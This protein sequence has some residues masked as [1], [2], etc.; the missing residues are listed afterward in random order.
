MA[1][2]DAFVLPSDVAILEVLSLPESVQQQFIW[3][4]GDFYVTRP[5]ARV[6]SQIVNSQSADLLQ[7]FKSPATLVQAV[8]N[9]SKVV[10]SDPEQV[11]E[12]AFPVLQHFVQLGILVEPDS[13][14]ANAIKPL[15]EIGDVVE[16]YSIVSCL[17]VTED[18]EVYR[19]QDQLQ[20]PA[21]LKILRTGKQVA[22]RQMFENECA[23]LN[24]LD[25]SIN[26]RLLTHGNIDERPYFFIEWCDGVDLIAATAKMRQMPD[27]LKILELGQNVLDAY[28]KLHIQQVL[29][30]DIHLRNVLIDENNKVKIIDYGL[31]QIAEGT[32]AAFSSFRGGVPFFFEPEYAQTILDHQRPPSA[33][34]LGEQYAL[35]AIM[36]YLLTGKHYLEFSFERAEMLR[37]ISADTPLVITAQNPLIPAAFEKIIARALSKNPAHRFSSIAAMAD[38][39]K[40]ALAFQKQNQVQRITSNQPAADAF[41]RNVLAR[42][43]IAG[44]LWKNG[45][46]AAPTVSVKLGAAGIAY[47]LYRIGQ[48][49]NDATL[50]SLSEVWSSRALHDIENPDAFFNQKLDLTAEMVGRIS[51]FHSP[52]GVHFVRACINNAKGDFQTMQS[53]LTSFVE[54]SRFDCDKLDLALGKAGTLIVA[55]Q[56]LEK[57]KNNSLINTTALVQ[58]GSDTLENIW[59]Q[60]NSYPMIGGSSEMSYLGIAHGWAGVLYATLCWCSAANISLPTEFELRLQQLI[61]C[62]EPVANGVRWKWVLDTNNSQHSGGYMPGWCNGTT[63]YIHLWTLAARVLREEQYLELARKSAWDAY[64]NRSQI[65]N[66]CCGLAGQ[67]YGLLNLY[68]MTGEREWL[69]R[70][71]ELT[72]AAI[73]TTEKIYHQGDDLSR[74][75]PFYSLYKGAI[76]IA[77]LAAEI[78]NPMRASFPIF[79]AEF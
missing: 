18:S 45:I 70:S 40:T 14:E 69:N 75:L 35:G 28:A 1:I 73:D 31:A 27:P 66:L 79:E 22:T 24:K 48:A 32:H 36:Q 9:Y 74:E 29:H 21:V 44:K 11:L 59:E 12:E 26:P 16:N 5:Q 56:L 53:A 55:S 77:V 65:G 34:F 13:P 43:G 7:Q 2:T 54:A 10:K 41:V 68:K 30:A 17:Q 39:W 72:L 50:F 52:S 6:A 3:E 57:T 37:Q 62:A 60:I 64:E 76:G 78:A 4:E 67:A 58:L 42:I 71:W 33:S 63:G 20:I 8:L 15:L 61:D 46:P 51:P 19:V 23:I 25:G 38:E 49:H 47:A